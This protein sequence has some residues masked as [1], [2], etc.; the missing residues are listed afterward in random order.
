MLLVKPWAPD[1]GQSRL[2]GG[3]AGSV[4]PGGHVRNPAGAHADPDTRLP[5]SNPRSTKL[6]LCSF[7]PS[8]APETAGSWA[9]PPQGQRKRVPQSLAAA[10]LPPHR[11]P[12]VLPL[13][14]GPGGQPSS[15]GSP[16]AM[17]KPTPSETCTRTCVNDVSLGLFVVFILGF[18][19]F[20][21]FF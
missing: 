1:T 19:F 3:V 11:P 5:G 9:E 6:P 21:F 14:I 8:H 2:P 18:G 12:Q 17:P 7:H 15:R 4:S 10:V 20:D 16:P 13:F